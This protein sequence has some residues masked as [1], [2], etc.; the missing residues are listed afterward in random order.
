MRDLDVSSDVG[1][2]FIRAAMLVVLGGCREAPFDQ[3]DFRTC[4]IG[5]SKLDGV[6]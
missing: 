2:E 3:V 4:V 6:F 1:C 5:P